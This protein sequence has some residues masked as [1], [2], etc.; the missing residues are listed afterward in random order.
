MFLSLIATCY[1]RGGLGK[2]KGN[3]EEKRLEE[4]GSFERIP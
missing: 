1:R 3:R 2:E 4:K